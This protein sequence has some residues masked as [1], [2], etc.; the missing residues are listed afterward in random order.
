LCWWSGHI[1]LELA[2]ASPIHVLD[3]FIFGRPALLD[4]GQGFDLFQSSSSFVD[5]AIN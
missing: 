4:I 5:D 3:I 1:I 2:S